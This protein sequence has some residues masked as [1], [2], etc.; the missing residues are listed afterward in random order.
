MQTY[1]KKKIKKGFCIYNLPFW[2]HL[3][4]LCAFGSGRAGSRSSSLHRWGNRST[5]KVIS[6]LGS[7]ETF[8]TKFRLESVV[9]QLVFSRLT[10]S[11][12][13]FSC[14]F[15]MGGS[16]AKTLALCF[17]LQ[18]TSLQQ[19]NQH[20]CSLNQGKWG[21]CSNHPTVLGIQIAQKPSKQAFKLIDSV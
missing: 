3:S 6:C 13:C 20:S 10:L 16:W 21:L 11:S 5:E 18:P 14:A 9:L 7:P 4:V 17:E 2:L 1:R 19:N 15:P 12:P 8:L